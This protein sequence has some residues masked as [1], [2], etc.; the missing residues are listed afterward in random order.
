MT[1][2]VLVATGNAHKAREFARLLGGEIEVLGF[3]DLEL[4]AGSP[5]PGDVE[6]TGETFAENAAIKAVHASRCTELPVLADDSGICIDALDG[7]PGVRS[8]RHGG[9]GL[10]DRQRY[11]LV[12]R[13][14]EAVPDGDRGARFRAAIALARHGELLRVEEG[15]VEGRILRAPRGDGGFG[16]DP[17]FFVEELGKAMAELSPAEKDSVSHRA[18]ALRAMRPHLP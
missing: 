8:A 16:Y 15:A 14:M 3:G 7:G 1:G 17:I 5:D 4:P 6:E 9:P 12:L 11:E 10:D 18:R 2:R 13:E